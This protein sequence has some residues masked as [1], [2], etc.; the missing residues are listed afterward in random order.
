[1]ESNTLVDCLAQVH[2]TSKKQSQGSNSAGVLN[3]FPSPQVTPPLTVSHGFPPLHPDTYAQ[4]PM[5]RPTPG[6]LK[7]AMSTRRLGSL[8][9][10][11]PGPLH[12]PCLLPVTYMGS[13]PRPWSA[14][15]LTA[16]FLSHPPCLSLIPWL[17]HFH[18]ISPVC[19]PHFRFLFLKHDSDH[20]IFLFKSFNGGTI[21]SSQPPNPLAWK[22][23][24]F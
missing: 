7:H 11:G 23:K 16:C 19:P 13:H 3:I 1:M 20:T 6:H 2:P 15:S 8:P 21:P 18:V 14:S 5:S 4:L 22:V 10:A 12:R 24:T 17:S 9:P